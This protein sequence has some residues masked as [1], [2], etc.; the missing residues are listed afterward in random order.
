[1]SK[2]VKTLALDIEISKVSV[3]SHPSSLETVKKITPRPSS[4][5]KTVKDITRF[6]LVA[7]V[8]TRCA[9]VV[10]RCALVAARARVATSELTCLKI[11]D[12]GAAVR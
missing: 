8:A 10:A 3:G 1:M 7:L 9:L 2:F 4:L 12:K 6:P 5:S 11:R